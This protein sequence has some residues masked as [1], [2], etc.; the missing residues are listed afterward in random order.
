[1][2]PDWVS[3]QM[4]R[5]SLR[6]LPPVP[7]LDAG[8]TLRLCRSE[9]AEPLA[10]LLDRSYDDELWT[11]DRASRELLDDPLV[12]E[13]FVIEERHALVATTSVQVKPG[14]EGSGFVHWVATDPDARRRGLARALVLTALDAMV[15]AGWRDALLDTQSHRPEA[16]SLYLKLGFEPLSRRPEEEAAWAHLLARLT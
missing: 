16:I 13:V 1:M 15:A 4:R 7:R 8:L 10:R 11:A 12:P 6:G 14:F 3:L 5:P 9:E 2:S